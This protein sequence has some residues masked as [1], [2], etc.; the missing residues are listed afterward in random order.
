MKSVL[1]SACGISQ[2]EITNVFGLYNQSNY[3]YRMRQIPENGHRL[4][5]FSFA[6]HCCSSSSWPKEMRGLEIYTFQRGSLA[7]QKYIWVQSVEIILDIS[8]WTLWLTLHCNLQ[9]SIII[10][11]PIQSL[12]WQ[13]CLFWFLYI[14]KHNFK[15]GRGKGDIQQL[16]NYSHKGNHKIGC[17]PKYLHI[18]TA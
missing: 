14:D 12:I 17:F 11:I 15:R 1:C 8:Y 2:A 6:S 16:I 18:R 9:W 7:Y 10:S 13:F 3:R 4:S 5:I